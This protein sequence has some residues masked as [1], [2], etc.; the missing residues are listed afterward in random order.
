MNLLE[1]PPNLTTT[2]IADDSTKYDPVLHRVIDLLNNGERVVVRS[3]REE[4][5][6]EI[7]KILGE[8]QY[9]FK[10]QH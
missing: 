9:E 10:Q 2:H 8:L 5:F 1:L 6:K 4:A 7:D 3:A